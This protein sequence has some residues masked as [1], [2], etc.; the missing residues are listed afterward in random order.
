[1]L[2]DSTFRSVAEAITTD[3]ERRDSADCVLLI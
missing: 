1:M 2:D 3:Q